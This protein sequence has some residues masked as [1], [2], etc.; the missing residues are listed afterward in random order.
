MTPEE[1]AKDLNLYEI[2]ML[3]NDN[4]QRIDYAAIGLRSPA[5]SLLERGLMLPIS[6][7]WDFPDRDWRTDLGLSV[8]A[9]L[10]GKE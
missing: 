1:I 6:E 8:A 3:M 2:D 5:I 7:Q 10:R 9:A 4:F